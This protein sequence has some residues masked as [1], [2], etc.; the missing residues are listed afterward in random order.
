M[1]LVNGAPIAVADDFTGDPDV[2][3]IAFNDGVQTFTIDGTGTFVV[4]GQSFPGSS[5]LSSAQGDLNGDGFADIVTGS[6][7]GF[8]RQIYLNDG[9]GHFAATNQSLGFNGADHIVLGDING[10]R[11]LDLV[12]APGHVLFNNGSGTF[13]DRG[14]SL[15]SNLS[16]ALELADLDGDHDLYLVQANSD[17]PSRVFLN[18]RSGFFTDLGQALANGYAYDITVGDMNDDSFVERCGFWPT[19]PTPIRATSCRSAR[20]AAKVHWALPCRFQR[21]ARRWFTIRTM[22]RSFNHMLPARR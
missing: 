7:N 17:G 13:T 1:S 4:S 2:V 12:T 5:G 6:P 15:G 21:T 8:T 18:N 20:L 11:S 10:D 16:R 22:S 9:S 14:Q 3:S 19:T